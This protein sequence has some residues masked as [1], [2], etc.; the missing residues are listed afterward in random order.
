M[1]PGCFSSTS[2][3]GTVFGGSCDA[4]V[5]KVVGP[6][7]R[8]RQRQAVKAEELRAPVLPEAAGILVS[9]CTRTPTSDVRTAGF[10]REKPARSLSVFVCLSFFF[11]SQGEKKKHL[12]F[13]VG[14]RL[15]ISFLPFTFRFLFPTP[16]HTERTGFVTRGLDCCGCVRP[17]DRAQHQ[18]QLEAWFLSTAAF[19]LRSAKRQQPESYVSPLNMSKKTKTRSCRTG[20][21]KPKHTIKERGK[22]P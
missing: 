22:D 3:A 7:G 11:C 19:C 5:H 2:R 6:G 17:G 16:H 4:T 8:H 13:R 21:G 1:R 9:Q 12:V 18:H 20:I 15:R 14:A 10:E